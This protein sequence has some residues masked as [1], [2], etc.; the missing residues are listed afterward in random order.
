MLDANKCSLDTIN[1]D[2]L[3]MDADAKE[4]LASGRHNKKRPDAK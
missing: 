4:I 2:F 3:L 1:S